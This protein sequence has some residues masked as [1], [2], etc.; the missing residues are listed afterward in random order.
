MP[1]TSTLTALAKIVSPLP[2]WTPVAAS[3]SS[4]SCTSDRSSTD[5]G[6]RNRSKRFWYL[7]IVRMD[8]GRVEG[9]VEHSLHSEELLKECTP[10]INMEFESEA[11]AFRFCN[12][13]GRII[14]FRIRRDYHNKSRLDGSGIGS[15][16][17]WLTSELDNQIPV[18][19]RLRVG[20]TLQVELVIRRKKIS[21]G[22]WDD[23]VG[24]TEVVE[25]KGGMWTT[26]GIVRGNKMYCSIEET[27]FLAERGELSV[28]DADDS[29][30]SLEDLYT[31]VA[32]ATSGCCWESFEVYRHL[33]SLGY[34]VQRHGNPWTMKGTK[35][36]S[37][38]A[39]GI[40]QI[41]VTTE[42]NCGGPCL[43][44]ELLNNM[45]IEEVRPAFDVFLPN[46]KFKKSSPGNPS[47]VLCVTSGH[48]PSKSQIE[49]LERQCN[50]I[51]LKFGHVEHG[52][53]SFFSFNK[54]E[55]PVLP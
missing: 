47:F 55:L 20:R 42:Q 7:F 38:S 18:E 45:R 43:I 41:K 28:L 15:L 16:I 22:S 14:G 46:S 19:W 17:L 30:I 2:S 39:V 4:I 6:L 54:V 32:K 29:S 49:D 1:K 35:N 36:E 51:P 11:A 52:R 40:P 12:E 23:E 3:P 9:S 33:R 53:V 31:K 13:H 44:N 26:T 24:M 21:R 37:A 34:I 8:D 10:C 5:E 27:L 48:P 50:G 25:K